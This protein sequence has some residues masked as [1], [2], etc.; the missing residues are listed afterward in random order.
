MK[1]IVLFSSYR[2]GN[3]VIHLCRVRTKLN[4]FKMHLDK[5]HVGTVSASDSRRGTPD[6][7]QEDEHVSSDDVHEIP[8]TRQLFDS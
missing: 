6:S 1:T 7:G 4:C 8:V 3:V 2:D 5:H